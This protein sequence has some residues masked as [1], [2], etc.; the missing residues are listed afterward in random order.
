MGRNFSSVLSVFRV[1]PTVIFTIAVTTASLAE[2]PPKKHVISREPG[3]W[4]ASFSALGD[5]PLNKQ[6]RDNFRS[7]L[8]VGARVGYGFLNGLSVETE[9]QY[10]LLF[11]EGGSNR[12]SENKNL[13]SLTPGLRYTVDFLPDMSWHVL[14]LF[15]S[16]YDY[17]RD[18]NSRFC[19]SYAVG[20]GLDF[21]LTE[22]LFVG[23][24]VR[25]R[26]VIEQRKRPLD[27]DVKLLSFG[28]SAS[29]L[30]D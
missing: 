4:M 15:G 27:M 28:V 22:N 30:Y 26:H 29:Y 24:T 16:T 20:T 25:Y 12:I 17:T 5:I 8:G 7:G 10:D 11:R 23:P 18:I 9:F 14:A 21:G 13:F 2:S 6:V 3:R 1:A 19:L